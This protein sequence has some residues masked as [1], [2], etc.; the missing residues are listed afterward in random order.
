MCQSNNQGWVQLLAFLPSLCFC[1]PA[2]V[3]AVLLLQDMGSG[4]T[5]GA[6]AGVDEAIP[7]TLSSPTRRFYPVLGV[8]ELFIPWQAGACLWPPV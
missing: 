8:N 7:P 2:A 1:F 3:G 6:G 5:P 4:L